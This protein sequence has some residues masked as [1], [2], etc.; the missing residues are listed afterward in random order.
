[1]INKTLR[2]EQLLK[3]GYKGKGEVIEFLKGRNLLCRIMKCVSCNTCMEERTRRNSIDGTAWI[4]KNAMGSKF[5]NSVSIRKFYFYNF[6][7]SLADIWT[8]IVLWLENEGV[9]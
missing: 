5:K 7:L 8:V 4:C 6:R 1:M 3:F 2:L 9:C